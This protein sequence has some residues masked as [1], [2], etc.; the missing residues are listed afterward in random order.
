MKDT[1]FQRLKQIYTSGEETFQ[2]TKKLESN[3][4]FFITTVFLNR[5]LYRIFFYFCVASKAALTSFLKPTNALSLLCVKRCTPQKAYRE[6]EQ[7]TASAVIQQSTG[8]PSSLLLLSM[9]KL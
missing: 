7:A 5:Q 3:Y 6:H 9:C 1:A 8:M 4:Y 2:T